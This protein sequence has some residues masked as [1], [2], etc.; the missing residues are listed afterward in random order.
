MTNHY[1]KVQVHRTQ[2][3]MEWKQGRVY[4]RIMNVVGKCV[5]FVLSE[6]K[7]GQSKPMTTVQTDKTDRPLLR[8]QKD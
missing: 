1:S 4:R 6:S 2:F 7:V 3:N 8:M 5:G